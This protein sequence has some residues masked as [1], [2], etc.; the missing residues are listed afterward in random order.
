MESYVLCVFWQ[1][2][3]C[4]LFVFYML[5][6]NGIYIY[7][8]IYIHIHIH[9]WCATFA[10]TTW[11]TLGTHQ[12]HIMYYW[13]H[14]RNTLCIIGVRHLLQL[15]GQHGLGD[16]ESRA[17]CRHIICFF[18]VKPH[19][20]FSN[21]HPHIRKAEHLASKQHKCCEC[22]ANVLRMCCECVATVLR[23]CC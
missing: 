23:M 13:K 5:C 11:P 6:L 3:Y 12:E 9:I 8:Y 2:L 21:P 18:V 16:P 19:F 10:A 20:F 15:H 17:S 14:I 1:F 22:V 4:V 7:I